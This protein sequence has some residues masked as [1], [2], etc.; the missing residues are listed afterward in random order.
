MPL[1]PR[2]RYMTP[3]AKTNARRAGIA[4]AVVVVAMT[5][6]LPWLWLVVAAAIWWIW[7]SSRRT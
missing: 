1:L 3:Q 4:V 7:S 2:W 5:L 6:K